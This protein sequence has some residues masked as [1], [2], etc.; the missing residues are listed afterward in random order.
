M[1]IK[2][3]AVQIQVTDT[4]FNILCRDVKGGISSYVVDVSNKS[5]NEK[6]ALVT[7]ICLLK[8][9]REDFLRGLAKG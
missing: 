4:E 9:G 2:A 5:N 7:F 1:T 3:D 6:W 8:D